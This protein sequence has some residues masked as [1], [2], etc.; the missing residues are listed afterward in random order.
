MKIIK[1]NKTYKVTVTFTGAVDYQ[2]EAKN[3]TEAEEKALNVFNE[4]ESAGATIHLI[5]ERQI[6]P[7]ADATLNNN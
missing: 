2:V 4:F 1:L 7:T 6:E 5:E 3:E